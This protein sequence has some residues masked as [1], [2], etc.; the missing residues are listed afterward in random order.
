M[1]TQF[2]H[3]VRA[4]SGTEEVVEC[5]DGTVSIHIV[6]DEVSD[7]PSSTEMK[8]ARTAVGEACRIAFEEGYVFIG[9]SPWEHGGYRFRHVEKIEWRRLHSSQLVSGD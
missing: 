7:L 3:R 5:G 2:I 9:T 4:L 8:N 6:G 1:S